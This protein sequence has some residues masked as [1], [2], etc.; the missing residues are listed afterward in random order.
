MPAT[1]LKS[2]DLG[3]L[4][5]LCSKNNQCC[6]CGLSSF[7]PAGGYL[8]TLEKN[9]VKPSI[10]PQRLEKMCIEKLHFMVLCALCQELP[11]ILFYPFMFLRTLSASHVKCYQSIAVNSN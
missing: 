5:V 6:T 8:A 11:G 9:Q 7:R 1:A 3:L 10:L 4:I 2:F